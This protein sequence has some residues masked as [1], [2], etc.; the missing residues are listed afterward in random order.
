MEDHKKKRKERP[1]LE[2]EDGSPRPITNRHK[3]DFFPTAINNSKKPTP[4]KRILKLPG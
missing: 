4:Q 3:K 2:H 1:F